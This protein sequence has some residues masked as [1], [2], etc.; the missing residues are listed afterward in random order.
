MKKLIVYL[1]IILTFSFCNSYRNNFSARQTSVESVLKVEM[2]LSAF[3]VESDGFPSIKATLDFE[4]QYGICKVS[5]D[6]PK[7]KDTTYSFTHV[8]LKT[9]LTFFKNRT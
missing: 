5:Y 9:F 4:K 8:E 6:D 2:N 7:F 3:G 1:S